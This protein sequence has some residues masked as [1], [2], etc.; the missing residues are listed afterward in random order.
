MT[1]LVAR[2]EAPSSGTRS[3]TDGGVLVIGGGIAGVQAALDLAEA[4]VR[5]Y[6]VERRP[7]IGGV[8]AQ[9]DKTFPTNDCSMCIL[10][11]KLV[12]AGRHPRITLLTNS[13]VVGL[14]GREGAFVAHVVRHPRYVDES[15]CVGC[16]RCAEKCPIKV[17]NEFN[18]GMDER[19]AIF[20][21]FPQAVP[22]K[23]AIDPTRCLFFTKG[24]CR[25]CEKACQAG[26]IAFD[27]KEEL[28]EI[29][30]GSVIVA[31]G[32]DTFDPSALGEYGYGKYANVV[33]S[34]ELER[35]I[36]ASGP[37]GGRIVRPSDGKVPR[38]VA[39]IQCVGS[40]DSRSNSYCS[41]VCC[42]YAMKEAI[43]AQE[44]AKGIEEMR[45]FYMDVRASG[46]EF[47]DYYRRARSMGNVSFTRSR[48]ALVTESPATKDLLLL[49][50]ADG[51][52]KEEAFDLV[53]LSVGLR[54]PRGAPALAKVLGIELDGHGFCRTAPMAPLQTSRGGVFVCG[55]FSGPRDIPDTVSQA[56]GAAA[57]ASAHARAA[58]GNGNGNG[59]VNGAR[60]GGGA[61]APPTAVERDV[62]KED[63]RIGVFVCHCGVNI[64]GVV[65]VP[66]VVEHARKLPYV[67]FAQDN[68][69]SCSQDAQER[70]KERIKEHNLNRVVVASCTP[71]THEPLFRNTV[72]EAGLNPYLFEMANIRDQCS[73]VHMHAPQEATRKAMAL[74]RMAVGKA[75]LIKALHTTRIPVTPRAL[76]LGGGMAGMTAALEIAQHGYETYLVEREDELGGNARRLMTFAGGTDMRAWLRELEERVR[77][78]RG[79]KVLTGKTV[80][81]I[82]GYVGNFRTRL[83]DGTELEHGVVVVATGAREVRP[84][85]YLYGEDPRVVTHQELGDAIDGA[86]VDLRTVVMVQCVG[87]RNEARPYCS[88][89][90]CAR[91]VEAATSI[92]DR[93]PGSRVYVLYRDMRTDGFREDAYMRAAERGVVFIRHADDAPPR[94]DRDGGALRVRVVDAA[95]GTEVELHPTLLVLASA[96]EPNPDNGSLAKMLKV[97]LSK[98]GFFLE[99]HMKL[100]PVDFS[101]DGVFLCG[102]AHWPK[103]A[104]E[105]VAQASAAAS[106]ALGIL[107]KPALEAGG[108]VAFIDPELCRGCGWCAK[109]CEF[110][111][112][113]LEEVK[114]GVFVSKVNEV[115]CKGCGA[116]VSVCPSKAVSIRHFSDDQLMAMVESLLL[117]VA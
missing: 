80:E 11:P 101:T 15:K 81:H 51:E 93:N 13:E 50:E 22:L 64:G 25:A 65:D 19:K 8:M 54:P 67:V 85:E 57:L 79:L 66:A 102:M 59:T 77:S 117:E 86:K 52:L 109:V 100:R 14:D 9:L 73:W 26:A 114:D 27:Q 24:K 20:V 99:A 1:E 60:N 10:A 38:R 40:R 46:K 70:M 106:R 75:A 16:G 84:T 58:N 3:S 103:F 104:D 34:L 115:L 90:C 83:S 112:V 44:H 35:M 5:A 68:L 116:C 98:D 43:V 48:V 62:S 55:T 21:Q 78:Q 61:G 56:S 94:V 12:E 88:R 29:G 45:I 36:N 41:S 113:A 39:F 4:G 111:A 71:R 74:V 91:S 23:Y 2:V 30:V 6:I 108:V 17:P 69:Y 47:E 63:I 49:H 92:L 110:S 82:G 28:L 89:V 107:T 32:A 31:T 7:S 72:R 37:T 53:V 33:T 87:S 105:A 42:M 18:Q 76:V 96:T 95:I 97:P